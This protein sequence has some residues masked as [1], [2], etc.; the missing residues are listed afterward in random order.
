MQ[1]IS[2]TKPR[3]PEE[4][5]QW[6]METDVAVVGFGGAGACAA[7]A[8]ADAGADVTIF[9]VAAASGGSTALSSAEIYFGGSGGTRVQK[10]CGYDDSTENM[11]N[12][13]LLTQGELGDKLYVI[14][15]GCVQV[16][17]VRPPRVELAIS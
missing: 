12:Y 9:E 10:A 7:I 8:A 4:V 6:H 16:W 17:K 1:K 3:R 14:L 13:M 15:T 5:T 2:P 11:L